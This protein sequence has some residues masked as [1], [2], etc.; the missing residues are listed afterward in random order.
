MN[1]NE[2][3]EI[4]TVI[5]CEYRNFDVSDIRVELWQEVLEGVTLEEGQAAA[6]TAIR[7]GDGFPPTVDK[8]YQHIKQ[9][10]ADVQLARE[11]AQSLKRQEYDRREQLEA[12]KNA[13]VLTEEQREAS[14]KWAAG[15][16]ANCIAGIKE[17]QRSKK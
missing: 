11:V 3:L 16:V 13:V 4:M 5:A 1:K 8:I 12:K 6:I 9:R 14:R 17:K 15:L 7:T 10:R 2:V